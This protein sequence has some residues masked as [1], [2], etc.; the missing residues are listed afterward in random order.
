[1]I[2]ILV[3]RVLCRLARRPVGDALML[4]LA[5][6]LGIFAAVVLYFTAVQHLSNIYVAEH[7]GIEDFILRSGGVITALFWGGQVVLGGL[8]PMAP[9]FLPATRISVGTIKL[10]SLLII[11]G[12]FSQVYVIVIGGQAFPMDIFPGFSASSSALDGVVVGYRPAL[13]ELLLG[14]GGVALA[15]VITGFGAVVLRILPT[16]LSDANTSEQTGGAKIA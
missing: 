10:A 6:L 15:L 7:G 3:L 11:L 2:F 9:L 5:R 8:L 4:R 1:A 12:G 14:L 13:V 16:S